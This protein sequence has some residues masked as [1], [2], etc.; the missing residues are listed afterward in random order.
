MRLERGR[1][2]GGSQ[3]LDQRLGRFGGREALLGGRR[4]R[5]AGPSAPVSAPDGRWRRRTGQTGPGKAQKNPPREGTPFGLRPHSAPR[6][7]P[8]APKPPERR[9]PPTYTASSTTT[10]VGHFCV[11]TPG[12]FSLVISSGLPQSW[13]NLF[14]GQVLALSSRPFASLSHNPLQPFFTLM[15]QFLPCVPSEPIGILKCQHLAGEARGHCIRNKR[16]YAYRVIEVQSSRVCPVKPSP[17]KI[18]APLIDKK[19]CIF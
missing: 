18:H 8:G 10:R 7:I 4:R 16:K 15:E 13:I 5:P 14:C 12:H 17:F 3:G 6:A 9:K 11:I 1:Q 19:S 2:S